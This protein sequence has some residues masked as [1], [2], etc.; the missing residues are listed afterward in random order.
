[1]RSAFIA[2]RSTLFGNICAVAIAIV[3][4]PD[5]FSTTTAV[6]ALAYDIGWARVAVLSAIYAAVPTLA[7]LFSHALFGTIAAGLLRIWTL[8]IIFA[9]LAA[10]GYAFAVI[11]AFALLTFVTVC[12]LATRAT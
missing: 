5:T 3:S 7:I 12:A 1:M 6:R 11:T 9:N 4:K 2:L 10:R 8:V